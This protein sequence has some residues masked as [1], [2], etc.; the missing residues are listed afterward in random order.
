MKFRLPASSR[1][2]AWLSVGNQAAVGSAM[3]ATLVLARQE[4]VG[5]LGQVV[6]AQAIAAVALLVIDIRFEDAIQRFYPHLARSGASEANGFFWQVCRLDFALGAGLVLVGLT[7]WAMGLIPDGGIWVPQFVVLGVVGAGAG[8]AL[9]SLN[10]GFAITNR[11][12]ELGRIQVLTTAANALLAIV[13]VIVDGGRGFL[14]GQLVGTLFQLAVCWRRARK[15]LPRAAENRRT[16]LPR[17]FR[18]FLIKS[19]A[20]STLAVGGEPGVLALAG[21]VGSPTLVAYL[22]VAQAPGRVVASAFSPIAVQAYPRL[23]R[24]VA[25][26][27]VASAR[28][29]IRWVTW[30]SFVVAA[31][32]V[33][34]SAP[35]MSPLI[36]LL[37]GEKFEPV[38]VA[39]TLLLMASCI[40]ATVTWSK[41]LPL[42]V[43]RPGLRMVVIGAE[44]VTLLVMMLV[45]GST[46]D[47]REAATLFAVGAV[48]LAAIVVSFW[49]SYT[50]RLR[51]RSFFGATRAGPPGG[52]ERLY[53]D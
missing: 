40:R 22:K 46:T 31:T 11:L 34:L 28:A 25:D 43:G 24:L 39:A 51:D 49:L 3:L 15:H 10:S 42:A 33:C 21:L 27:D 41:V 52:P 50:R 5:T 53:P 47:A 19:S 6:F 37:Y 23:S 32:I 30:R 29:L 20:A 12:A 38:W 4:S 7:V 17:G 16:G 44:S 35:F 8:T 13:G 14:V 1:E 2:F 18:S 36:R 26:Q 48:L 9:G 45:A